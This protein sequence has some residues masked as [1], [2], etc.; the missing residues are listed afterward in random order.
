[1]HCCIQFWTKFEQIK[2]PWW[3]PQDDN[4]FN[5][6]QGLLEIKKWGSLQKDKVDNTNE[7]VTWWWA[8]EKSKEQGPFFA[9]NRLG[10]NPQSITQ[11]IKDYHC[12]NW[13]WHPFVGTGKKNG[14][15]ELAF[16]QD[17]ELKTK[18]LLNTCSGCLSGQ[19][20]SF[21]KKLASRLN[22]IMKH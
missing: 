12:V 4:R 20:D 13:S 16:L 10:R 5:L 15:K 19:A 18:P 1:M 17:L 3:V 14:T 8:N 6:L 9:T 2:W 11:D 7:W 21:L 22:F